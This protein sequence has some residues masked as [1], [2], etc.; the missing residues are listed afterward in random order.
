M[1]KKK[2][3]SKSENQIHLEDGR[4]ILESLKVDSSLFTNIEIQYIGE[5]Q[6]R[7]D[8]ESRKADA[9]WGEYQSSDFIE[10]ALEEYRE[11]GN[12][13]PFDDYSWGT[14]MKLLRLKVPHSLKNDIR[15]RKQFSFTDIMFR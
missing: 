10:C 6:E 3:E 11:N 9:Y 13:G 8:I 15:S 4:C 12:N 7:Y 14:T 5:K 1:E 2:T